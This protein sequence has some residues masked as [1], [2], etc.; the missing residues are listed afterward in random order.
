MS[1]SSNRGSRQEAMRLEFNLRD[2]RKEFLSY[3]LSLE[4]DLVLLFL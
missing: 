4:E 1:P 2:G 3:M